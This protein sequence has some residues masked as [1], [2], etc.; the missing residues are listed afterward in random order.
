MKSV[1]LGALCLGVERGV[2]MEAF[3]MGSVGTG[4]DEA[5]RTMYRDSRKF[6]F[7]SSLSPRDIELQSPLSLPSLH[8]W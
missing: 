4:G 3:W 5:G 8:Y 2:I 6:D 1:C 7:L